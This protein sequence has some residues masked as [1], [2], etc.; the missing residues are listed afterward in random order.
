MVFD[1]EKDRIGFANGSFA[2]NLPSKSKFPTWAIILIVTAVI[3]II[4]AIAIVVF[5]KMR[6]KRLK[7]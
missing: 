1:F 7:S 3:A 4:L 5:I 2:D 6:N